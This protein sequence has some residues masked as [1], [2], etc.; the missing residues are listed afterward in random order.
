MKTSTQVFIAL[1]VVSATAMG[2]GMVFG[3]FPW[4]WAAFSAGWSIC[5][6]LGEIG[7]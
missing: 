6:I 4:S 7:K 1:N 5:F 2:M 3:Y